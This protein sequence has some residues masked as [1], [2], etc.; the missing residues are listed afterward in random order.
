VELCSVRGVARGT[1]LLTTG[2]QCNA[3]WSEK[4]ARYASDA[5]AVASNLT[6][7]QRA[8]VQ[9]VWF[10]LFAR[11]KTTHGGPDIVRSMADHVVHK[12]LPIPTLALT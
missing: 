10:S 12:Q 5:A 11:D 7:L 6:T 4:L 2:C 8:G 9:V 3:S 1:F